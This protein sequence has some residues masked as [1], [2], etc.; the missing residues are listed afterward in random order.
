M[1]ILNI[2]LMQIVLF[3]YKVKLWKRNHLLLYFSV[4]GEEN[5]SALTPPLTCSLRIYTYIHTWS[6]KTLL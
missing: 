6:S 4:W 5:G 3:D 2:L 1:L